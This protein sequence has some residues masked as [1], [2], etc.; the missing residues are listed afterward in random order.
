M[1]FKVPFNPNHFVVFVC[2]VHA[3]HP[4]WFPSYIQI[5]CRFC[6]AADSID[7][8]LPNQSSSLGGNGNPLLPEPCNQWEAVTSRLLLIGSRFTVNGLL[9]IVWVIPASPQ[10]MLSLL[11]SL[12]L[13]IREQS[14]FRQGS[15]RVGWML[16][17]WTAGSLSRPLLR[18]QDTQ[19]AARER[20]ESKSGV[21]SI[22]LAS[23]N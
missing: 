17:T 22:V 2:I 23:S 13:W 7:T 18:E 12:A 8:R 19:V 1:N 21:T 10:R 20:T 9:I 15:V 5:C 6:P 11:L 4:Q 14:S 16:C 3:S